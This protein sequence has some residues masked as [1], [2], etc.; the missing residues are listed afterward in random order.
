MLKF[1]KTSDITNV[2]YCISQA[3]FH[4]SYIG[5][6]VMVYSVTLARTDILPEYGPTRTETCRRFYEILAF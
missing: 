4:I 5:L 2:P 1:H 3:C 6:R